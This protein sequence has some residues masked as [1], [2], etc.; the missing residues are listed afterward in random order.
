MYVNFFGDGLIVG[1][2]LHTVL[3]GGWGRGM[4]EWWLG[5]G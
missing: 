2:G 4:G 1:G 5:G 3:G